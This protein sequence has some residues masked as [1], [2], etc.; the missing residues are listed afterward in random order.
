MAISLRCYPRRLLHCKLPQLAAQLTVGC[1][2]WD[3]AV[4]GVPVSAQT[5]KPSR[6]AKWTK[7]VRE[8]SA[9]LVGDQF[10]LDCPVAVGVTYFYDVDRWDN[11]P[12]E[13]LDVDN[14]LKPIVDGLLPGII[15]DDQLVQDVSGSRRPLDPNLRFINPSEAL[16]DALA[17]QQ[18]FVLIRIGFPVEER[19]ILWVGL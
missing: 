16:V 7:A 13:R 14:C 19:N 17:W 11:R 12:G 4:E 2:V 15:V 18:P 8:R 10:P 9:N 6:K 3:F 5:R 1:K